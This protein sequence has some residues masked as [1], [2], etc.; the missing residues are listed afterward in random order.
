VTCIQVDGLEKAVSGDRKLR[1]HTAR[2]TN[3][4]MNAVSSM[5]GHSPG[6]IA[7]RMFVLNMSLISLFHQNRQ[8]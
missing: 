6:R 1:L 8:Q 5:H 3:G 4:I 7:G 2:V